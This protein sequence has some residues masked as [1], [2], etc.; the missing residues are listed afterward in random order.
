MFLIFRTSAISLNA[1][2]GIL[3]RRRR[4]GPSQSHNRKTVGFRYTR[5]TFVINPRIWTVQWQ[6]SLS[7]F[8]RTVGELYSLSKFGRADIATTLICATLKRMDHLLH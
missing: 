7:F 5:P 2:A 6:Y 3:T 4:R 1:T 8:E